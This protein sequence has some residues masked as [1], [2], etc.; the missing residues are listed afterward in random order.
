MEI[1]TFDGRLRSGI[2][3]TPGKPMSK[4]ELELGFL[5][6]ENNLIVK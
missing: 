2:L 4:F 6:K 1:H 3:G 5:M